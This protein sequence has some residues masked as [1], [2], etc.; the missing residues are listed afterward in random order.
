MYLPW[1]SVTKTYP[2]DPSHELVL[3]MSVG[4]WCEAARE[5]GRGD[6][7]LTVT[8]IPDPGAILLG[9][10][11]AGFVGWLRRRRTL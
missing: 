5:A 10:I 7:G 6:L 9:T 2:V 1:F 8:A 3:A 4:A 11:G